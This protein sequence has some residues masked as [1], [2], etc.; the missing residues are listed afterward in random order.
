MTDM[1]HENARLAA[2]NEVLR[3]QCFQAAQA[4]AAAQHA[5]MAANYYGGGYPAYPPPMNPMLPPMPPP[6][7][8]A[9][10]PQVAARAK[11]KAP[12]PLRPRADTAVE[13][14]RRAPSAQQD[15]PGLRPRAQS[16]TGPKNIEEHVD[17]DTEGTTVMLRN[18][19]NNYTRAMMLELVD[20]E[21]FAGKYDFLY[22]PIDFKSNSSLGYAFANLVDHEQAELFRK[23]FEGFEGWAVPSQKVCCVNWSSPFQG[24]DAHVQRFRNSP[25]M[26][27]SVPDEHKPILF[28]DGTRIPFP[29]PTKS[30]R[31]PRVRP[32]RKSSLGDADAAG[33]D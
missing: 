12:G 5:A 28:K 31:A 1:S 4:A 21:G 16:E 20:K 32:G 29:E 10:A 30:I 9:A 24:L 3:L 27:E 26:H 33:G 2:E 23:K 25:V 7:L 18:L 13:G 6:W 15:A 17:P 22:L 8:G 14:R 11:K 19:P